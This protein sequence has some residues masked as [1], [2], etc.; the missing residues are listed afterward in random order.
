LAILL[1]PSSRFDTLFQFV[2]IIGLFPLLVLGSARDRL[3]PAQSNWM[4]LGGRLSYPI[5]ML[6]F[7]LATILVPI[8]AAQLPP[9]AAFAAIM[10]C[11]LA[12]SQ[13]A[14]RYYDEPVRAWLTSRIRARQKRVLAA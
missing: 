6:H 1:A 2:V 5:Y 10:V 13:F 9:G 4:L 12:A 8:A 11:T 7:P 3:T 14:V